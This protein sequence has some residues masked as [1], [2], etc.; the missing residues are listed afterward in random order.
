[1]EGLQLLE[2]GGLNK[3]TRA[4]EINRK[5]GGDRTRDFRDFAAAAKTA[6][7]I[8]WPIQGPR[9]VHRHLGYCVAQT[10]GGFTARVQGFAVIAR[11]VETVP[12]FD[13]VH[14]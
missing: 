11:T 14:V 2:D 5:A 8:G 13:Q 4:L 9:I 7:I 3:D 10:G 6:E 1:M 12:V